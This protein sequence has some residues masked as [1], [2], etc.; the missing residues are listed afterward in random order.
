M[1][2]ARTVSA[3]GTAPPDWTADADAATLRCH[4]NQSMARSSIESKATLVEPEPL[5]ALPEMAA[6]SQQQAAYLYYYS[7]YYPAAAV[8]APAATVQAPAQAPASSAPA[9]PPPGGA[10]AQAEQQ[11]AQAVSAPAQTQA[12]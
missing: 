2:D 4:S 12:T 10:A 8:Q 6:M 7:Y 5:P 9:A 3:D 1:H 11:H